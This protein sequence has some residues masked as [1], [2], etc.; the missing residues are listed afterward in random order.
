MKHWLSLACIL[1]VVGC[2]DTTCGYRTEDVTITKVLACTNNSEDY[3]AMCRAETDKG[4]R[5]TVR[6][7]V[8]AGDIRLISK[9]YFCT[10]DK[11]GKI[12]YADRANRLLG[13]REY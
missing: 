7:P 5:V 13:N 12:T 2:C 9:G 3:I 11:T 4:Y 6:A 1:L 10:E 8:A